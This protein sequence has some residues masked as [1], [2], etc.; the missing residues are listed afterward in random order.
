MSFTFSLTNSPVA[1]VILQY[2]NLEASDLVKCLKV[3][4]NIVF[5]DNHFSLLPLFF[6]ALSSFQKDTTQTPT[7]NL[8]ST[9]MFNDCISSN[10]CCMIRGL[11]APS[12]EQ[13]NCSDHSW[14]CANRPRV[15][16]ESN[17]N[18]FRQVLTNG[19]VPQSQLN[20]N[21]QMVLTNY[22]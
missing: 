19:N 3:P 21:M 6:S 17:I 20:A 8:N 13:K 7:T 1:A 14:Q 22:K 16:I 9:L 5:T 15:L 2:R 11:S 10:Q 12:E 4:M 18:T